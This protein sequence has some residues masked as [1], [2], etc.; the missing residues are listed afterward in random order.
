MQLLSSRGITYKINIF[1]IVAKQVKK[2]QQNVPKMREILKKF[3]LNL[4]SFLRRKMTQKQFRNFRF[5]WK[6]LKLKK[7]T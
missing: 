2:K 1:S 4:I 5:C 3:K 7:E 6:S